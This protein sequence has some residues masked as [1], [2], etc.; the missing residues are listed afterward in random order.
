MAYTDYIN[1]NNQKVPCINLSATVGRGGRNLVGDVVTIQALFK[2][3]AAYSADS[4]GLG[5]EFSVPE[6]TGIMDLA[7]L[8]SITRLHLLATDAQVMNGHTD[9]IQEIVNMDVRILDDFV[10]KHDL[11]L[12]LYSGNS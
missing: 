8:L 1:F 7:R 11:T 3:I 6:L 12:G 5:K 2:Y 10:I 9:Y 4:I